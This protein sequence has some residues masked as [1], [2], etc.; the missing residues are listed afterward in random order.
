MKLIQLSQISISVQSRPFFLN[1][2]KERASSAPSFTSIFLALLNMIV[3]LFQHLAKQL[4]FRGRTVKAPC[5]KRD[6]EVPT[7]SLFH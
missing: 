2:K 4:A 3:L 5:E 1:N 7:R 6:C